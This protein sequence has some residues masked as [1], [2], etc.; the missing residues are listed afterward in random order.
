MLQIGPIVLGIAVFAQRLATFAVEREA[1]GVHEDGG[2]VSEQVAAAV[3]QPLLD[4]V[5]DAARRQRPIRLSS[6]SSPS[7]AMAR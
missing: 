7:Q 1:G 3:E 4:Q 5:L 2:E 6:I